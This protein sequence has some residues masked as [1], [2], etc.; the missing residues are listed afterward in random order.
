MTRT[1]LLAALVILAIGCGSP[2]D[3]NA[4]NANN[5]DSATY[6][7]PVEAKTGTVTMKEFVAASGLK[8][9]PG[10]ESAAGEVFS[11]GD[12]V[13][14]DVL[15]FTT[16]DSLDKIATFY[17]GEGMDVKNPKMPIGLTKSGAQVKIDITTSKEGKNVVQITGLIE[18]KKTP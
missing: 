15:I 2:A 5:V 3:N 6:V 1:F 16:A 14:K 9:Y 11:H 13:N 4:P 10:S 7:R 18:A 12:G 17:K 8:A